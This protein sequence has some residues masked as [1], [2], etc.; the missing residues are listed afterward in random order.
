MRTQNREGVSNWSK[1]FSGSTGMLIIWVLYFVT[2]DRHVYDT[3]RLLGL[4]SSSYIYEHNRE[5]VDQAFAS[6]LVRTIAASQMNL[7]R[8]SHP[9]DLTSEPCSQFTR[10]LR[11]LGIWPTHELS[12]MSLSHDKADKHN[13]H[14]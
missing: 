6:T 10:S 2:W 4:H 8:S 3:P 7:I 14:S 5:I 1:F 12:N 11:G 13:T 9:I